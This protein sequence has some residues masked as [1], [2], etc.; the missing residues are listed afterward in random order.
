MAKKK[1]S[2]KST[3]KNPK[4]NRQHLIDR[5]VAVGDAGDGVA[6]VSALKEL[7]TLMAEDTPIQEID[8]RIMF[9]PIR[10]EDKLC[11]AKESEAEEI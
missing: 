2:K 1:T 6:N 10:F 3:P 4:Y 8:C 7:R 5:L 9:V 11:I